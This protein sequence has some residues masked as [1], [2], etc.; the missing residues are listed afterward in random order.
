VLASLNHPN[1]ATIHGIEESDGIRAIVM[2]L[3]DGDTLAARIA[4]RPIPVHDALDIARQIADALEA[5]HEKGIVHR[6][7]K[8]ANIKITSSGAVK[9]LDFGLAKVATG[10]SVDS[11]ALTGTLDRTR[12]GV[13]AGTAAYMSPEQARGLAVD[14]RTDIWAFGCVLFEMLTGRSAF[15]GATLTDTLA[16]ILEREPD[17]NALPD[18]LPAALRLVLLRC[19]HKEPRR[20]IRDIGDVRLELDQRVSDTASVRSSPAAATRRAG[21]R[22]GSVAAALG[23]AIVGLAAGIFVTPGVAPGLPSGITARTITTQLTNHGGSETSAALSPD[24]RSFLFVSNHGGTIDI[25]LRQISGGDPIR[26]T[27]DAA[28]EADLAYAPDGESIYFSRSDRNEV[29]IWRVGV[30]GGQARKVVDRGIKPAPSPDGGYLA[31]VVPE[32]TNE[33]IDDRQFVLEVRALD[34]SAVRS[35]VRNIVRCAPRPAWSR[36]SRRIAYSQSGL[37]GPQRVFVIDAVTGT[38]LR[39]AE[40]SLAFGCDDSGDPAWLPDNRHLLVTYWPVPRQQTPSDLGILDTEDGSISRLTTTLGNSFVAPSVSAE[41][42]RMIAIGNR[43]VYELWKVPL[44]P[45]PDVNGRSA[46]RL[47]DGGAAPVWT[48]GSRDGHLLLFNSPLSGSRNLWTM[49][50]DVGSVP[51]QVTAAP[52][53]VVAHSSLSPDGTQV[54]FASIAAG[55]SDIWTQHI[56]GSDL[57]QLTNDEAAD[58]WPVWSPDG[59]WIAF[60]S[61]REGG[62]DPPHSGHGRALRKDLGWVFSRRL[63]SA[64]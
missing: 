8:P 61:D 4:R 3:V 18:D 5:A 24:G 28:E 56:D 31:Y 36:D 43:Y 46:V 39:S 16:A 63:D 47:L 59:Q 7:L 62:R 29:G 22:I 11:Q 57:R 35:L 23:A 21:P 13:I 26:L 42:S 64:P 49:A 53:D 2:E 9:V 14:K 54:A 15:A 38:Q 60:N 25:W 30:L 1:I 17:W 20:R 10:D 12:E 34:G 41:G 33:P 58:S 27:N 51:R 48:F 45:N 44:G 40:I 37:F 32:E 50:P 55:H 52:G 19:L 6:D